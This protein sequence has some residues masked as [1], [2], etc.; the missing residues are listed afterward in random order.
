VSLVK[1]SVAIAGHSTSVSLEE[2]FWECLREIAARRGETLRALIAAIDAGR[3][4]DNLSSAIRLFV[5]AE[6]RARAAAAP[7][8]DR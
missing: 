3:G 1:R 6:I 4:D 5:L 2:P 7:V 8:S